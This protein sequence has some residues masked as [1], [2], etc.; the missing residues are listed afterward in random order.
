MN[1]NCH[2]CK[3]KYSSY[4]SIWNHNKKF[5][6]KINTNS[7]NINTDIDNNKIKCI[8]CNKIYYNKYT[9]KTHLNTCAILKF[10]KET[11]QKKLNDVLLELNKIKK[12]NKILKSNK[13]NNNI[14]IINNYLQ[15]NTN[16]NNFNIISIGQEN[17]SEILSQ[18]E[19]KYIIDSR[20]SC[21][22]ELVKI[23]HC[24]KYNQ[25]HAF[26][27]RAP[28]GVKN[29][30]ITNI[31]DEYAYKYDN[32]MKKFICINKNEA[33]SDLVDERLDNIRE[34][35]EE[36]SETN[37][38][39][40]LTKKLIKEFLDKMTTD[41]KYISIEN[42]KIYKNFRSYKEHKV[43]ILI[44]NNL[45]KISKDLAIILDKPFNSIINP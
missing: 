44:Y 34:L 37:K 6:N 30:I 1:F 17:I 15:N 4:Q 27:A 19:K 5:H 9:L 14:K 8:H 41:D 16:N 38:I 7:N 13:T 21:L 42:E 3:K 12:E 36:L 28:K 45:D 33:I 23:V 20:Y 22:E 32:N 11:E 24:N 10:N 18:I 2:I 39:N 40:E 26:Q 43:K 25:F 31:K 29:I 35:Y